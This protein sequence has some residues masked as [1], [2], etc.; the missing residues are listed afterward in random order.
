MVLLAIV[1]SASHPKGDAMEKRTSLPFLTVFVLLAALFAAP[2][3]ALAATYQTVSGTF[4]YGEAH[5]VL[6]LV[7]QI[8]ANN[9]LP[10][11]VM[12]Q[13]LTD[14]AMKRAAE[15]VVRWDPNNHI[16]PNGQYCE[17]AWDWD[18]YASENIQKGATSPSAAVN[19]WMNSARHKKNILTSKGGFIGIGCFQYGNTLYWVQAFSDSTTSGTDTRSSNIAVTVKVSQTRGADS[20]VAITKY[21]TIK[22]NANGGKGSMANQKVKVGASFTLRKNAFTRSGCVFAGWA[23][24]PNGAVVVGDQGG[25]TVNKEGTT[26]LYAR[27][28]K[29]SAVPYC[30]IK[31]HAN[32]GK[33]KMSN[34]KV[35]VGVKFK[36]K[37][38]AFTRSGYVFRGWAASKS[39]SVVV[40]NQGTGTP[41]NEGTQHLYAKWAKKSYKVAFNANG[42]KGKM[43]KQ[44]MTWNKAAKLR[45]NAFTRKGC[46]FVGWS[47]TKGGKVAYKNA[48]AVKNL[49]ASGAVTLYAKWKRVETV[50]APVPKESASM[51]KDGAVVPR[52]ESSAGTPSGVAQKLFTVDDCGVFAVGGFELE[53][54]SDSPTV[55]ELGDREEAE[56]LENQIAVT[57]RVPAGGTAWQ[58]WS[59]E[60]GLLA[61]DVVS[62]A[63]IDLELP[64][65]GL[66]HWLRF[67]DEEGGT[68]SSTWLFPAAAE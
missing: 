46:K 30:T 15:C 42:G 57:F 31:F 48:Q 52:G 20:I 17:T 59:A 45:K 38:N 67:F 21:C 60:R 49:T 18:G 50:A 66:W 22:F 40:G 54:I 37:K 14:A 43:A 23:T 1:K 63:T 3:I 29:K 58:F 8:R 39:G 28:A 27:W 12:T 26:I 53:V 56:E 65:L 7:N 34:Q 36:L 2:A 9:G 62:S 55:E 19:S 33:G 13:N 24:S 6:T 64:D 10:A 68:L 16:R 51:P 4:R 47:K 41:G 25:G 5:K 32:G 11:L 44:K 35:K 61:E